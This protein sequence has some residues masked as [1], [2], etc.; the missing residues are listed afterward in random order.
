MQQPMCNNMSAQQHVCSQEI[1]PSAQPL[2][3]V[4]AS[5][6]AQLRGNTN[7]DLIFKVGSILYFVNLGCRPI[8]DFVQFGIL[9]TSGFCPF[10]ILSI[11]D[12]V[13]FGILYDSDIV[14]SGFCLIRDFGFL[15][16]VQFRILS[17]RDFVQF[18]ILSNSGYF[19]FGILF[20]WDFVFRD[21]VQDPLVSEPFRGQC[22]F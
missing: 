13:Q 19:P 2:K 20:D 9:S 5:T 7:L 21:F 3:A 22:C 15:D 17:I 14:H 10:K 16:F 18:G 6:R 4:C 8:R 11:R 12:F 1:Y